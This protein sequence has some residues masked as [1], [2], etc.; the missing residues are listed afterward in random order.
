MRRVR[1]N[2]EI[3][4][5]RLHAY[6]YQFGYAWVIEH[7]GY[8]PDL[9]TTVAENE[10]HRPSVPWRP[11]LPDV[12][13]RLAELEQVVG[14]PIP[15]SLRVWH[16]VVGQV[17]FVGKLPVR[18][19]YTPGTSEFYQAMKV[20][21]AQYQPS[22]L[23]ES[24]NFEWGEGEDNIWA[25]SRAFFKRY[26]PLDPL[27]VFSLE[28]AMD[29][30]GLQLA[31]R[32]HYPRLSVPIAPDV[33]F[34]YWEA[35]GGQYGISAPNAAIDGKLEVEW[36]NLTFVEY[37]RLCFRW[38]GLPELAYFTT[39]QGQAELQQLTEGLLPF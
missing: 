35:G 17:N 19:G 37:L 21:P 26:P 12:H 39:E 10:A 2:I 4:V 13:K 28:E 29:E 15:L 16:E 32:Q 6:G 8:D 38:A 33:A 23:D 14:G 24:S 31:N 3:L 11:P 18:W 20:S 1:S 36:H 27:Y 9:V 7:Q 22:S 34:K 5:P 30:M 25:N